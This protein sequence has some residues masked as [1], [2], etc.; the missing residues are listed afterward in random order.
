MKARTSFE[1]LP[2]TKDALELHIKR[3]N[4]QV[5]IQIHVDIVEFLPVQP[6]HTRGWKYEGTDLKPIWIRNPSVPGSCMQLVTCGYKTKCGSARC[7]CY[8]FGQTCMCETTECKIQMV[9]MAIRLPSIMMKWVWNCI[10]CINIKTCR[11]V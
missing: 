7:K 11:I 3:A 4:Y 1:L 10:T 6:E 9:M 5:Q 8:R 2:P